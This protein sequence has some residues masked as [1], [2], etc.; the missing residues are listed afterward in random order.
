MRSSN[1]A[2]NSLSFAADASSA[3]RHREQ[4]LRST[5]DA[6]HAVCP[7]CFGSGM[8][9]VPGR[10]A[11]R[12][13]CRAEDLSRILLEAARIP[14]RFEGCRLQSYRPEQGN[15]SQLK[16]LSRAFE[17]VRGEFLPTGGNRG[18]R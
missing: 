17:L 16:A 10:G 8:E 11:R 18:T 4:A 3:E 14:R 6:S 9:V 13:G 7:R 12:C 15:A 2:M 5:P 1:L